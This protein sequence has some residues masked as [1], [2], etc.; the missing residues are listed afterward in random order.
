MNRLRYLT[1]GIML[2]VALTARTQQTSAGAGSADNGQRAMQSDV[3][4]VEQ[5]V[6]VLTEKLGLTVDQ[7][8]KIKPIL[9]KLNDA[10]L[11][12][13]KNGNLTHEERLA[14]IRPERYKSHQQILGIL[15]DDQK[16]KLDQYLQG[17]HSEVHGGLS[18][19]AS[20]GPQTL[21]N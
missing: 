3:P 12:L 1:I 19:V 18:G 9:Q 4:A 10:T 11:K 8:T 13:M 14:K 2:I 15:S 17:P 21:H 20:S 7:Q 5:Q 6:K 16:K